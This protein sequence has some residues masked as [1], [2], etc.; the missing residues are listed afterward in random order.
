MAS[1]AVYSEHWAWRDR[2]SCDADVVVNYPSE[3]DEVVIDDWLH[4][5]QMS[6][7]EWWLRVGDYTINVWVGERGQAESVRFEEEVSK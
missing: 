7:R 2:V 6:K 4:L 5:E 3:L 1:S